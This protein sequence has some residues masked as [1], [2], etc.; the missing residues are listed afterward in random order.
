M[1]ENVAKKTSD[2]KNFQKFC[3]LERRAA[4]RFLNFGSVPRGAL[5]NYHSPKVGLRLKGLG[6]PDLNN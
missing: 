4:K 6:T 1:F 2:P 5:D 3:F